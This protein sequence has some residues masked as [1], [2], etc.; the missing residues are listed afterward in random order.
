ML[1]QHAEYMSNNNLNEVRKHSHSPTFSSAKRENPNTFCFRV[2]GIIHS[3][4]PPVKDIQTKK[5]YAPKLYHKKEDQDTYYN[6]FYAGDEVYV[7]RKDIPELEP[8][9]GD[10][11][12]EARYKVYKFLND[13]NLRLVKEIESSKSR[14]NLMT[15]QQNKD[16][17]LIGEIN[18]NNLKI[19][20]LK[21]KFIQDSIMRRNGLLLEHIM[22]DRM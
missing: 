2:Q 19:K 20:Q 4:E 9:W 5:G 16:A 15:N 3:K 14:E 6:P 10:D 7:K 22:Y 21:V 17:T 18:E 8:M 11:K 1:T 13:Q 12:G